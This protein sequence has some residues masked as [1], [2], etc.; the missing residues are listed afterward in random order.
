M[1]HQDLVPTKCP[2]KSKEAF[3]QRFPYCFKNRM[4]LA[5]IGTKKKNEANLSFM[6]CKISDAKEKIDR[7]RGFLAFA[8]YQQNKIHSHS[9]ERNEQRTTG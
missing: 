2:H 1:A 3:L 4:K 5:V 9:F 6:T 8:D 7:G